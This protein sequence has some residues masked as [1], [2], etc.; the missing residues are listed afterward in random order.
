M[1]H[2]LGSLISYTVTVEVT[3]N[4]PDSSALSIMENYR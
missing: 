1:L 3:T 4:D 2:E